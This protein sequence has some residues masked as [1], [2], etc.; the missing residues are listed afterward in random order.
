MQ[1]DKSEVQSNK[2]KAVPVYTSWKEFSKS[3]LFRDLKRLPKHKKATFSKI[4]AY[5]WTGF[6]SNNEL[7][8]LFDEGF[9]FSGQYNWADITFTAQLLSSMMLFGHLKPHA[10]HCT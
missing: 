2:N 4:P 6:V 5:V 8:T 7:Y 9:T 3:S 10:H 1:Q